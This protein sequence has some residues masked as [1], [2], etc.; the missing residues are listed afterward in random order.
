M[1]NVYMDKLVVA[2]AILAVFVICLAFYRKWVTRS[3][4]DLVHLHE[5]EAPK[6]SQQVVMAHRVNLIDHWGQSLTVVALVFGV[7]LAAVYLYE[8]W[9]VSSRLDYLNAIK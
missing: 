9:L 2:W 3:E 1:M 6:V 8:A 7:A 4:D 5:Y